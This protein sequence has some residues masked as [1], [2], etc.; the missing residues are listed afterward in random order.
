MKC[1]GAAGGQW[2][3]M[4]D[5]IAR[6]NFLYHKRQTQGLSAAEIDEQSELRRQY[7]DVIKGNVKTELSRIRVADEKDCNHDHFCGTDCNFEKH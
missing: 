4:N 2:M 3:E 5:L 1:F 6:L 7:L